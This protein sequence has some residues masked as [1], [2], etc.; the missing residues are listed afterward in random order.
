MLYYALAGRSV[1]PPA[2]RLDAKVKADNVPSVFCDADAIKANN[3]KI[4]HTVIML[5]LTGKVRVLTSEQWTRVSFLT[6]K[7]LLRHH[8]PCVW[9]HYFLLAVIIGR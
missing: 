8:R 1:L 2:Y 9:S 4:V 3:W 7:T 5:T 6:R